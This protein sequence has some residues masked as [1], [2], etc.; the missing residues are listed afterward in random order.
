ME[1]LGKRTV[2]IL[3]TRWMDD[4]V[5]VVGSRWKSLPTKATGGPW[6]KP[7]SSSRH[8]MVDIIKKER[9]RKTGRPDS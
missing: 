5:M 1:T 7:M 2:G 8:P 4:L 9:K 6:G 3:P